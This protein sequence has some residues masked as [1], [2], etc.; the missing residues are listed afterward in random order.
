M[1][2][3][4]HRITRQPSAP[5]SSLHARKAARRGRPRRP[6]VEFPEVETEEQD[7]DDIDEEAESL[8]TVIVVEDDAAPLPLRGPARRRLDRGVDLDEETDADSEASDDAE[9]VDEALVELGGIVDAEDVASRLSVRPPARNLDED[10]DHDEWAQEEVDHDSGPALDDP[11]RIYLMQ[12]G[13]IPMLSH[14]QEQSVGKRIKRACLRY[15]FHLLGSGFILA[16]AYQ[17]LK[18][19]FEGK[20]RL[21]RT[22]EVSVTDAKEKK[23]IMARLKPHLA[24]LE[25][26]MS[27]NAR[28]FLR[29]LDPTLPYAQRVELWKRMRCRRLRAARLVEELHLRTPRLQQLLRAWQE[30]AVRIRSVRARWREAAAVSRPEAASLRRELGALLLAAEDAPKI[31]DRHVVEAESRLKEYDDAKRILSAGN[32]RLVVSIAKRYRNRGMS[33]LDL[34]QEGNTGLMRAVEKFE[35]ARGYKFSTYATWWI[36]QAITRALADQSRTIRVPIHMIETMKRVHHL[37]RSLTVALG[38]EATDEEIAA[39][40]G[41]TIEETICALKMSRNPL[42]LDQPLGDSDDSSFGEFLKDDSEEDPLR[43]LQHDGLK[44]QLAKALESLNAREREI[45]RLR[46]GLTDGYS[47]TLEEVGDIFSVTRE[48]VRQIEAKA[49]RKLQHPARS[50]ELYG[51]LESADPQR[52]YRWE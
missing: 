34:I 50:K 12:M 32:L 7:S 14:T 43:Q 31:V 9:E 15:R 6:H 25:A 47:Y 41:M 4:A 8:S 13:S 33:F 42:S 40:A 21:D 27:V 28:D 38:R 30:L 1:R 24:T 51:Y 17:L 10:G 18:K 16:G 26:I 11:V 36:R 3:T 35:Y 29:V 48:R 19:V 45:L 46:F 20:L 2:R 52:F 39:A 5:I 49:V 37:A 23:R 22:V 44:I